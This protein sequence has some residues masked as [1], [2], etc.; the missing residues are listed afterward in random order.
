MNDRQQLRYTIALP[1]LSEVGQKRSREL[2]DFFGSAQAVFEASEQELGK[3]PGISHATIANLMSSKQQALQR[4]DQELLFIEKNK[5]DCIYY[6]DAEYP[7]RLLE[8][9]D[10]PVL[11]Y[12]KGNANLNTTHVVSVVGTR[13]PTQSGKDRCTKL[14]RELADAVSDL[15]IVSGLAYGIDVTS[16]RAAIELGI[17]T[18][19]IPGHGLDRIY[20]YVHRQVAVDA[21]HNGGI[22]T[23]YMSQTTPER[24]N[25]VARNR[26]I[27]G[28][29]D[30]V[31]VVESK[32]KGG[33][34]ITAEMA[35]SYDRDLFAFP[36]RPEDINAVGCNRLI[37]QQKAML[38]ESANDL[39]N[40]MQWQTNKQNKQTELFIELT[41][42][43][44]QILSLLENKDNGEHLNYLLAQ[45][46]LSFSQLTTTLFEME[47]KGLI[48]ALPGGMY[49]AIIN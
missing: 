36:G 16:H 2:I 19:I 27:A 29:A 39:V 24:Q 8:C 40:A 5:I 46:K 25:F 31:V 22:L 7:Y 17:P 41:D 1:L 6:K 23:E 26:I 38:I 35:W 20:P 42:T 49:K 28:L 14:V 48:R 18:L 4:A 33:S 15:T 44:Q 11:L 43:E 21:L 47:M 34:L 13:M 37:K 32:E 9:T 12:F 3:I 10:A 45:M 30:A